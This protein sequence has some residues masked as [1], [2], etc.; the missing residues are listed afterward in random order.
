MKYLV[1]VIVCKHDDD[2]GRW[3]ADGRMVAEPPTWAVAEKI[4]EILVAEA[5]TINVRTGSHR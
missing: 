1:E 4:A 2:G 3:Q 5:K